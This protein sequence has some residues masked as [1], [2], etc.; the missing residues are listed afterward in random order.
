MLLEGSS[1]KDDG[2]TLKSIALFG[3]CKFIVGYGLSKGASQSGGAKAIELS[4]RQMQALVQTW[5]N[6]IQSCRAFMLEGGSK[7]SSSA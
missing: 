6:D 7:V 2:A 5:E 1:A 3:L 4:A